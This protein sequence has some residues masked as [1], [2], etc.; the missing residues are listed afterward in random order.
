LIRR[1]TAATLL[2]ACTGGLAQ[3]TASPAKKELVQKVLALQQ[4]S[5]DALARGLAEQSIAPLVQQLGAVLQNR[6]PP[7]QREATARDVQAE[8]KKYGDEVVPLLRDR[9]AKLAPTSV[10]AVL[11]EK[12]SEDELKQLITMLEAPIYR[13]YQSMGGEMQK[14]LMEKLVADTRPA[15][16]PKLKA[17]QEAVSKRLGLEP[18]ASSKKPTAPAAKAS[19]AKK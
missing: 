4:P 14:A 11:E 3:G 5:F 17:L 12:L 1:I 15:V 7:E 16:E 9:A 10:G 19:A 2:T 18:P 13:K 8:I 6:V